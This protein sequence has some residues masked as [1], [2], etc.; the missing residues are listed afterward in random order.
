[1]V[2]DALQPVFPPNPKAGADHP[3]LQRL[4][5]EIQAVNLGQLLG[6][7][8]RTKIS[9]ALTHNGQHGLTEHRTTSTVAG[10]ATLPRNQTVRTVN[11]EH[12]EQP[13]NLSSA[14]TDQPGSVLDR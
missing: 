1:M 10:P 14:D 4:D 11:S 3:L 13:I 8:G 6:H 5:A 12:I 9:I 2:M 7:Q